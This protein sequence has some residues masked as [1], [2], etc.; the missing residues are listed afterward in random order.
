MIVLKMNRLEL[1]FLHL[2]QM[3]PILVS[4][5]P[6]WSAAL[7]FR[8][9]HFSRSL[10]TARHRVKHSP[11]CYRRQKAA[12][13]FG[14]HQVCRNMHLFFCFLLLLISIDL[15]FGD[16]DQQW[17]YLCVFWVLVEFGFGKVWNQT[18][19]TSSNY[20]WLI[21][22][23]SSLNPHLLLLLIFNIPTICYILTPA[24]S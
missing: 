15:L 5:T 17:W 19:K 6:I 2:T 24:N 21:H 10:I 7:R 20:R 14:S 16:D 23:F 9:S 1:C 18:D 22:K 13:S 12:A 8:R 3:H 4:L 11:G